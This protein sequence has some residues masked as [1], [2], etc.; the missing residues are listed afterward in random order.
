[1]FRIATDTHHE[2]GRIIQVVE[3]A[4]MLNF[5]DTPKRLVVLDRT[6][7]E[8][9]KATT[10]A[11]QGIW[12]REL[13]KLQLFREVYEALRRHPDQQLDQAFVLETIILKT[14]GENYEKTFQTFIRWARF[15]NLFLYDET[16][17]ALSFPQESAQ[18]VA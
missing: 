14:P 8:F 4:E 3:A 11:R 5:V 13:L 12:R 10:E 1:M 7:Q 9:V 16:A 17:E 15:G 6:G 18:Q 2:F